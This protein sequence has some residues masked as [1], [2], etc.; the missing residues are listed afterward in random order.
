MTEYDTSAGIDALNAATAQE[1]PEQGAQENAPKKRRFLRWAFNKAA[2]SAGR[3]AVTST[4]KIAAVTT[5]AGIGASGFLTIATTAMAAGVGAALYTYGKDTFFDW[6]AARR[7]GRRME[8]WN[9]DRSR[10]VK[11]AL[12]TGV[13]GGA[14]GAWLAGTDAFHHAIGFAKEWGGKAL[15]HVFNAHAHHA[16]AAVVAPPIASAADV[17]VQITPAHAVVSVPAHVE[18]VLAPATVPA[19]KVETPLQ[20]MMDL[21]A[22]SKEAHGKVMQHLLKINAADTN[23]VSPQFLKDSAHE[24]LRMKDIPWADRLSVAHALGAEAQ[25]R[26]NHQAV[27]FMKDLAKL[28]NGTWK[29]HHLGIPGVKDVVAHATPAHHIAPVHHAVAAKVPPVEKIALPQE[30]LRTLHMDAQDLAPKPVADFHEAAVCTISKPDPSGAFDAPCV[31][32]KPVMDAGDYVA[33]VARE[34]AA[35]RATT[36][37]VAGSSSVPT[38]AF[39]NPHMV[40]DGVQKITL[41]RAAALPKP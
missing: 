25:A 33:F 31:V 2:D 10:K 18:T 11:I 23:S 34:N 12:L 29:P 1:L 27:Q 38:Q 30:P 21:M 36:P 37:L 24:I 41:A 20:K 8:W 16:A 9:K 32:N 26:G 39:L 15:S 35:L 14:F 17:H 5:L 6:R 7:D 4:I 40:A 13:A 19:V 28:E 22:H 3:A